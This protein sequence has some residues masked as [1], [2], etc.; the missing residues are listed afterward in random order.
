[1]TSTSLK[2]VTLNIW[3]YLNFLFKYLS[4]NLIEELKKKGLLDTLAETLILG[5]NI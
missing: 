1:M 5:L 3:Y 2:A 4:G